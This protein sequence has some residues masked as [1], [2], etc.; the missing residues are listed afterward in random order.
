MTLATWG[1][2]NGKCTV[3]IIFAAMKTSNQPA[4]AASR[5]SILRQRQRNGSAIQIKQAEA[6]TQS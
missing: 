1:D 3:R 4:L 2:S 6:A 5:D